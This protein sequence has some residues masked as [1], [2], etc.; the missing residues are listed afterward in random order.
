MSITR[1][2]P[3]PVHNARPS[4]RFSLAD[5]DLHEILFTDDF[6][7]TAQRYKSTS[8]EH[9]LIG[10]TPFEAQD[11][12]LAL[13]DAIKTIF[14]PPRDPRMA[15][16]PKARRDETDERDG[17]RNYDEK[18]PIEAITPTR[19]DHIK[20]IIHD[21]LRLKVRQI[22]TVAGFV[23]HCKRMRP[24]PNFG[25]IVGIPE[26]MRVTL[27]NHMRLR[28]SGLILFSGLPSSGKTSTMLSY[29]V[30]GLSMFGD[31]GVIVEERTEYKLNRIFEASGGRLLQINQRNSADTREYDHQLDNLL[32]LNPRYAILGEIKTAADAKLAIDFANAGVLTMATI[33]AVDP[34]SAIST[35]ISRAADLSSIDG[36]R[37]AVALCIRS[38]VHQSLSDVASPRAPEY[39]QLK[40]TCL[41]LPPFHESSM[42]SGQIKKD[43]LHS[44]HQTI[45]NQAVRMST[46]QDPVDRS[47]RPL[48][49]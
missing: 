2:M 26:P 30:H 48:Q 29:A 19:S 20:I 12:L 42:I 32:G 1:P 38:I 36:A 10:Q 13:A 28:E 33:K 49:R 22:L 35:L 27:L 31:F 8:T 4:A 34:I 43:Q 41:A 18:D 15:A 40:T 17:F 46:G 37:E 14:E 24:L 11:S 7:R 9:T 16:D 47:K 25:I 23:Y 39:R 3:P 6:R 5:L 44:L 45:S 21:G